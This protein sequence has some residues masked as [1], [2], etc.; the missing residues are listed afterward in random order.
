MR[1]QFYPHAPFI[2][3]AFLGVMTIPEDDPPHLLLKEFR[4]KQIRESGIFISCLVK[5]IKIRNLMLITMQNFVKT[6]S[7][8][9]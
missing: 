2:S 1:E 7:S 3:L 5:I 6:V 9:C 8:S 4:L